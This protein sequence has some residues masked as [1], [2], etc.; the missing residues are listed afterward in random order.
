MSSTFARMT[1]LIE[2]EL[3]EDS[4]KTRGF[5]GMSKIVEMPSSCLTGEVAIAALSS[6]SWA[7]SIASF[8]DSWEIHQYMKLRWTSHETHQRKVSPVP[9]HAHLNQIYFHTIA[10]PWSGY[11]VSLLGQIDWRIL[12][13]LKVFRILKVQLLT[14]VCMSKA[15]LSAF[16]CWND[17]EVRWESR[18]AVTSMSGL[19]NRAAPFLKLDGRLLYHFPI[20]NNVLS[21]P[22]HDQHAW[23]RRL[24]CLEMLST[25]RNSALPPW[26]PINPWDIVPTSSYLHP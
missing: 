12:S 25:K 20:S 9:P 26:I 17:D 19:G 7:Y 13:I 8:W 24:T 10:S 1:E 21:W 11:R 18:L 6:S 16:V 14:L 2:G 3:N 4:G 15:H 23:T 22:L 5:C